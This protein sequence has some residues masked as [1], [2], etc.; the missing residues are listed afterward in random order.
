VIVGG[1]AGI[2]VAAQLLL[3][4]AKLNIAIIDPA[5]KHYC[6][7]VWTLVGSGVFDIQKTER[8]EASVMPKG[9]I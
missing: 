1:K 7:P 9:V 5:E 2:S 4:N 6:Q 8:T 3:K